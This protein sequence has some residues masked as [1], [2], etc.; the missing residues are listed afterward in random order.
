MRECGNDKDKGSDGKPSAHDC[1]ANQAEMVVPSTVSVSTICL[2]SSEFDFFKL[3]LTGKCL[4]AN[5]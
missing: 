1:L 3:R 5:F 2:L 4:M